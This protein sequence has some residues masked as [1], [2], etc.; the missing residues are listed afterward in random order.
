MICIYCENEFNGVTQRKYCSDICKHNQAKLV[1]LERL[2]Q[3]YVPI[4]HKAVYPRKKI[5]TLFDILPLVY[6]EPEFKIITV[7]SSIK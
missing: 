2:K 1:R 7:M 6:E 5:E 3:D 4:I